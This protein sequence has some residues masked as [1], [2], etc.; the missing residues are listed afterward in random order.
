MKGKSIKGKYMKSGCSAF[1]GVMSMHMDK[2]SDATLA[3][4]GFVLTALRLV[5][6]LWIK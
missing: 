1:V 6:M 3:R 4:N 2:W 5:L